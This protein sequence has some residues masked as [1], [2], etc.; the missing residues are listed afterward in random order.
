MSLTQQEIVDRL[1]ISRGTL[2]RILINSPLV[3]AATR[4]RVLR[5]LEQLHYVPNAIARGLKMRRTNTLGIIGPAAIKMANIDKVNALYL[6]SRARGYSVM[7]GYSNGSP[8]ED[9][10]CIR[11]LRSRMVDGFIALGR[12]TPE[13]VPNYRGL[14]EAGIPVVTLYPMPELDVDC[15]FVDTRRAYSELTKHLIDLGHKKIGLL[16]DA[17]TSQFSVNRELGFRDAMT[18]AQLP[19]E[20]SWVVRVTP[21]GSSEMD[22]GGSED[23][24]WT[25]SDYQY[26]F[27]GASLMLARRDRPTA[28]VCFSDEFAIG[29][30]RAADLAG[31]RV[32]EE[33]AL[34][35]YDDKDSAK[36]AR[37]PLTT[38]HQ[39]DDDVGSKAVSLLL[40]RIDGKLPPKS[41]VMPLEA[42]LVIRDSCGAKQAR[43]R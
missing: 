14:A 24:I 12:G 7:F 16:L 33:L 20:E 34:V 10:R 18:A 2:H 43:K 19:V 9:A 23:R 11:E 38:M 40:D 30:L 37:V 31:V 4:E 8:E 5:E 35:G 36:F 27:W 6:A 26:G 13:S 41:V 15:V 21:D 1:G 29:V 22:G 17:S 3:K 39:P 25:I 32:P 42:R 28:L